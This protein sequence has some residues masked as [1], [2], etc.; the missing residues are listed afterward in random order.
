MVKRLEIENKVDFLGKLG[1]NRIFEILSNSDFLLFASKT[2]GF[3]KVISESMM[4]GCIPISTSV[5]CINQY[6][7]NDTGFI[8]PNRNIDSIARSINL[9]LSTDKKRLKK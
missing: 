3:P 9:A 4:N 8:I 2:E 6:V 5:S 7:N 1:K